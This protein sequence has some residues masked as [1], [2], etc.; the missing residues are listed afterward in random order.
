VTE[1]KIKLSVVT[2]ASGKF[3]SEGLTYELARA[4][5]VLEVF[6]GVGQDAGVEGIGNPRLEELL[7]TMALA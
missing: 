5:S 2:F 7:R 3:D 1:V 6:Y 4:L